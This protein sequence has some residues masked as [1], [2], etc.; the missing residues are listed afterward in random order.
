VVLPC[1][2]ALSAG[3]KIFLEKQAIGKLL[4]NCQFAAKY[5]N[6]ESGQIETYNCDTD[7]TDVLE[8]GLCIFHEKRYLEGYLFRDEFED[9]SKLTATPELP[10]TQSVT[11]RLKEKIDDSI[12][13]QKALFCIGYYFPD[14][15]TIKGKFTKP[16]YFN[17]AKIQRID[18]SFAE[19]SKIA[20]FSFAEFSGYAK[21]DNA[22]FYEAYFGETEFS[23]A[24]FGE[25]KFHGE[26]DFGKAEFS[27]IVSFV[28]AEF[29]RK[30]NFVSAKF[31][32]QVC[33]KAKFY[34]EAEFA[35][36]EFSGKANFREAEL[37]GKANFISVKFLENAYFGSAE[38]HGEADFGEAKFSREA[39]F[40]KAE[41]HGEADFISVKFL[42]SASF[43]LTEFLGEATF[44]NAKFSGEAGFSN[45]K[46]C[47]EATF[48]KAKF[49][50]EADFSDT[51]KDKTFFNYVL[52]EDGKKILF[53]IEDLSRFSFMGT[54]ITRVRFS[55]RAR[56][57]KKDKFKVVEEEMLEDSLIGNSPLQVNEGQAS[58]GSVMAVY[59]N[60]RENYEYR[61]RYDEAGKFFF[62]EMELK[63]KYKENEKKYTSGRNNG[64]SNEAGTSVTI[65]RNGWLRRN[66]SLTGLYYHFSNYGESIA[67][68]TIIGAIIV[69][70]STL[71]WLIQNNPTAE[72]SLSFINNSSHVS[73]FI[74]GTYL[75]VWNNTHVL[76]AFERSLGDILPILDIKGEMK[77]GIVDFIVKIVGG[78]L[79]FVLLGVALRRKFER[80]YTR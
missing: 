23:D 18:F 38:F 33:F 19:F 49:S 22:E 4:D 66:F 68:P 80:K 2:P 51:F 9:V 45:A 13:N 42:E 26:A 15:I 29:S 36:A 47:G 21:F 53:R 20:D 12:A 41:F 71:F 73:N 62:K 78:A 60:L 25:A 57:G 56:W 43:R 17:E 28:S 61:L 37:F 48:S 27:G 50:G 58:L 64:S 44:I 32:R 52:F 34:G 79:T 40:G 72:P 74:N 5:F 59:R 8:S 75:S 10:R 67:K 35:L 6:H 70:L 77:V 69:G 30:A 76:K 14:N 3:Q 11:E 54:D 63:R 39:D 16:V 24:N 31:S 46:F 55:D 65:S 7:N 1:I